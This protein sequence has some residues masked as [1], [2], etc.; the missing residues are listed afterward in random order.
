MNETK[1]LGE[2]LLLPFEK[3]QL[4]LKIR[5]KKE[6][7]T[8][9]K[10]GI[11]PELQKTRDL[12][13]RGIVIID[14][15]SGPTSHQIVS[16]VKEILDLDKAGHSGTLDPAVTG[17]LPVALGDA[18]RITNALLSAGKE[19]V[20]LMHV[21]SEIDLT[22]LKEVFDEFTG[23]IDQ[24]PPKKSAVKRQLRQRSIYY[25]EILEIKERDVLFKVGCEAGT[26]IRKLVHDIGLKLGSGAHMAEL[27]RTK[28]GP[29]K[30]QDA[31]TLHDLADAYHYYTQG[32]DQKLRK[33][34][35]PLEAGAAHLKKIYVHDATIDSLCHGSL[36]KMPGIA[37][38]D[39]GIQRGEM[40][41]VMSLKNELVMVGQAAMDST[42][43]I[44]LDKGIAVK[45]GQ[46]FMKPGTYPKYGSP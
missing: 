10:Y 26:Y 43:M 11:I 28:A 20:C 41:A 2:E 24:M 8:D 12:L 32:D 17:V 5:V 34:L 6:T 38:L 7:E 36:L 14:K 44:N 16:Y 1:D 40:I 29:F 25:L 46:V 22:R 37:K 45:T 21:H 15:P 19:Y 30:E 31:V 27:R 4:G 13:R 42:N 35:M 3:E 9:D 18:T 23:K 33:I 39:D